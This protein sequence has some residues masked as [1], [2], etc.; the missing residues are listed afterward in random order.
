[1]TDD[2]MMTIAVAEGI[3]DKE[4]LLKISRAF[5]NLVCSKPKDVAT[6]SSALG[7]YK[8]TMTG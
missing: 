2:T 4:N 6:L 3:L 1:M 5:Y 8:Q 7:E